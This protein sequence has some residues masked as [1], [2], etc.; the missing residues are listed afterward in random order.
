MPERSGLSL[1]LLEGLHETGDERA[2]ALKPHR[3][4]SRVCAFASSRR[5]DGFLASPRTS[6]R[7][8]G[9]VQP[10][11]MGAPFKGAGRKME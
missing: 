8:S 3:I 10:R 11:G 5:K 4:S 6:V 9:K 2:A 1:A 7:L